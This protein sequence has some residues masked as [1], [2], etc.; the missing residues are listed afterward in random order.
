MEFPTPSELRADVTA[1]LRA[2]PVP[3]RPERQSAPIP[4]RRVEIPTPY[5]PLT[6]TVTKDW[7]ADCAACDDAGWQDHWCPGEV[8]EASP[9][10]WWTDGL[11]GRRHRET[12]GGHHWASRCLCALTNLT[13]RRRDGRAA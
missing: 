4:G 8:G 7:Y 13:I 6:V 11:C 9:R 5:G 3:P 2:R 1:I 12:D 10:V